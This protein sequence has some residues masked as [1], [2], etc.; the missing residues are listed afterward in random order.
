MFYQKDAA[1]ARYEEVT[2][3]G[4]PMLFTEARIDRDTVPKGLYMYE[5]RHDD[6]QNG[7]PVQLGRWIL[8]NFWGTVISAQPLDWRE[9]SS[10]NYAY[11]DID[12]ERDWSYK[13]VHATLK[14]YMERYLPKEQDAPGQE[15]KHKPQ[16]RENVR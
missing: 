14:E 11:L 5:V 9:S 1:K 8:V 6:D 2:I 16:K 10:A 12:P 13:G 3:L 15:K 4:K 7:N